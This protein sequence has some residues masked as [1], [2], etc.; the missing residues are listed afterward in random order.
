[1]LHDLSHDAYA[2]QCHNKPHQYTK[3]CGV[4]NTDLA[5][6]RPG[7]SKSTHKSRREALSIPRCPHEMILGCVV[8]RCILTWRDACGGIRCC[9]LFS[10]CGNNRVVVAGLGITASGR[11]SR[12]R[13]QILPC[14][15]Q[16]LQLLGCDRFDLMRGRQ[17]RKEHSTVLLSC[18]AVGTRK[19]RGHEWLS[20]VSSFYC[21]PDLK[22]GVKK[23]NPS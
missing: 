4:E 23:K 2:E 5:T 1:M 22:V 7:S 8:K 20:S 15:G 3:Q 11:I 13:R 10:P 16:Q 6:W 18:A 17:Q 12:A 14:G 9:S 21:V 19:M